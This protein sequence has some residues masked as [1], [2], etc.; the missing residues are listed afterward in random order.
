M[1]RLSFSVTTFIDFPTTPSSSKEIVASSLLVTL[2]KV[3]KGSIIASTEL[4][5][6][7]KSP[8]VDKIL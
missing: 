5:S 4:L 2:N 6:N 8:K 3:S 1:Y 7:S